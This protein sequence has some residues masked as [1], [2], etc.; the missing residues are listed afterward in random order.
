MCMRLEIASALT[1]R[2]H[3]AVQH[4]LNGDSCFTITHAFTSGCNSRPVCRLCVSQS[5]CKPVVNA[6]GQLD[7]V[8]QANDNSIGGRPSP[9][10]NEITKLPVTAFSFLFQYYS[11][12]IK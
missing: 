7:T 4:W 12:L 2:L 10:N 1:L 11:C 3:I 6:F 5:V 8:N 9:Q